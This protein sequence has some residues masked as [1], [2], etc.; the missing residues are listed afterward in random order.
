MNIKL[1]VV[2]LFVLAA[3]A[4]GGGK[5]DADAADGAAT[6]APTD[7]PPADTGA[8]PVDTAAPAAG[9]GGGAAK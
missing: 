5:K 2:G 8:A 1:V 6:A 7:A 3:V 4:C 9:T